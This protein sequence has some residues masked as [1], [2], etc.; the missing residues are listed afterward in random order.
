MQI[1]YLNTKPFLPNTLLE[2]FQIVS[3]TVSGIGIAFVSKSYWQNRKI[4]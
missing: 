4:I 3:Y 1:D 2:W